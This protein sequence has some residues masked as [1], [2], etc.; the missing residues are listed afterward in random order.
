VHAGYSRYRKAIIEAGVELYE[1]RAD[2][3]TD[4]DQPLTLHIK[5]FVI[6][7]EKAFIGSLNLDPRSLDINTEMGV[8]VH[9]PGL[10]ALMA[11]R[12]DKQLGAQTWR[13][14]L[15]ERH[16]LRWSAPIDGVEVVRRSEPEVGLFRRLRAILSRIV[17]DS[18]L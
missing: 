18:Q 2:T 15:D 8:I 5:A 16:S 17:P 13:L 1:V 6:D 10:A 3:G 7:R 4:P 14:T 11:E 9:S 12:V